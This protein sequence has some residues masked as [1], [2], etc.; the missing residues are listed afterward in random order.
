MLSCAEAAPFFI[1]QFGGLEHPAGGNFPRRVNELAPE[2]VSFFGDS[3][4]VL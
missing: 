4:D 1:H 2:G 3:F